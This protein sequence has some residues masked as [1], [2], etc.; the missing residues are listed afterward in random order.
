MQTKFVCPECQNTFKLTPSSEDF[1]A[2]CPRCDAEVIIPADP[3]KAEQARKEAEEKT[4]R[5][6][7]EAEE[8]AELEKRDAEVKAKEEA[9]Q[10]RMRKQDEEDATAIALV[11]RSVKRFCPHC[12]NEATWPVN[13]KTGVESF[14][15]RCDAS[16]CKRKF[17][18]QLNSSDEMIMLLG[19]IQDTQ[20]QL[21]RLVVAPQTQL[22]GIIKELEVIRYRIGALVFWFI[23]IPLLCLALYAIIANIPK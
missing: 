23:V 4:E 15:V 17:T 22:A 1:I 7:R 14:V 9:Q 5:A 8:K 6:R 12:R 3:T 11:G 18:I 2:K 13:V 21:D 16:N 10:S 20:N 19:K